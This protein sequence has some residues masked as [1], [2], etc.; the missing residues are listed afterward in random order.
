MRNR[1]RHVKK[2]MFSLCA[3]MLLLTGCNPY[4]GEYVD[5]I[6]VFGPNEVEC[7][8]YYH[9]M[10]VE[11]GRY[12]S[13]LA[14]YDLITE[15]DQEIYIVDDLEKQR[16]KSFCGD[17]KGVFYV[18]ETFQEKNEERVLFYYDLNSN[19]KEALLTSNDHLTVYKDSSTNRIRVSDGTQK[20]NID[21]GSLQLAENAEIV[22]RSINSDESCIELVNDDG[23][24]ISISKEYGNK[25]FTYSIGD[26]TGVISALSDCGGEESGVS[27]N[28][29]IEG[30]NVVG[31]V[32]ITK[33]GSGYGGLGII[34]KN[35][36]PA[37]KLKREVLV[38]FDYTTSESEILFET[39]NNSIRIIG[40]RDGNVYLL[41]KGNIIKRNLAD[42]SETELCTLS[43]EGDNQLSFS[44]I[45]SSLVI[46]DEDDYQVIASV[47]T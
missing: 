41:N 32:Q 22:V 31:V 15:S 43:Y 37:S 25:E 20:Y 28:F 1:K 45:G 13:C 47:Q 39:K 12:D 14:L 26:T 40:Y 19:E 24:E 44:W 46:F 29:I 18:V 10:R 16:I 11:G 3:V 33:G 6:N 21:N 9:Y 30:N 38:S 23:T 8:S 17:D 42:G 7:N 35:I 34:P 5:Y 36:L 4:P 27:Y 2:I